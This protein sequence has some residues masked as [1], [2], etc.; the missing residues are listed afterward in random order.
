[1]SPRSAVVPGPR[2]TPAP[3]AKRR[4]WQRWIVDPIRRQLTQGVSPR[5]ITRSLAVGTVCSLLPF[6]GLTSLLNLGVGLV[7][8]L[9]QPILQTLNQLLTPVH[10]AFILLYVRLG[11]WIWQAPGEAFTIAG[12]LSDFADLPFGAFLAKF[13]WTGVHAFTAWLLTSPLLF[14][15]VYWPLRPVIDRLARRQVRTVIA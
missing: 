15:A 13:G 1:M 3:A 10:L 6:I 4:F 11:E 7:L 8:R 12:L 5:D 14:A 9:N 2:D